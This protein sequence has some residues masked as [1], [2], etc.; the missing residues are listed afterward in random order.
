MP[1][2]RRYGPAMV[3]PAVN[4][5]VN[6]GDGGAKSFL[7]IK[8]IADSAM[9][10]MRPAVT[11]IQTA[12]GEQEALA[13]MEAS[14]P[15]FQV[16]Q[17]SGAQV[18]GGHTPAAQA[19]VA[20]G[21]NPAFQSALD[22]MIADAPGAM[23]VS[24][25][26]RTPET[27]AQ[28][29]ANNMTRAKYGF[30]EAEKAQWLADVASLGAIGAG[31]VWADRFGTARQG[32]ERLRNWIGLPGGSRHQQGLAGDLSFENSDVQAWAHANAANYGL[33][34]PMSWEPW[35]I[36]LQGSRDAAP[37]GQG[38][39]AP[40]I[41]Q[42]PTQV[43]AVIA[44]AAQRHG[45]NPDAMMAVAYLESRFD[46]TEQNPE[47][48]AG[49]LFQF[50]DS[51]AAQYGLVDKM[52]MAQNADA[53][54]RFMKD[55]IAALT[56]ALGR[57]PSI[58]E[59]YL[60]HQQGAQGAIRLLSHPG[61]LAT[62]IV[63]SDAVTLNG[64]REN[65]TA[66]EFAN[67]WID[68]ANQAAGGEAAAADVVGMMAADYELEVTNR[69]SFE[70][71]LPFTIRSAAFNAAADRVIGERAMAAL[72][73]GMAAAVLE[74]DGDL[75]VMRAEMDKVRSTI[76]GQIPTELPGLAVDVQAAYDRALGVAER[77]V[78]ADMH[79]NTID[80]QGAAAAM[81]WQNTEAE[82]NRMAIAGAT[83]D[84]IAAH[85]SQSAARIAQFGP[86]EA[87]TVAGQTFGADPSRAGILTAA[88]IN[89]QVLEITAAATKLMLQA[90]FARS[91][92]PTQFAAEF[93]NAVLSGRSPL[94][95]GESLAL[96]SAMEAQAY[97]A[98]S[99][100]QT[101]ANA[102]RRRLE[103]EMG[104][105]INA[106][107]EMTEAGVPVAIPPE[108]RA[109]IL[110]NLA[111]YPDLQREARIAFRVADAQVQTHG[112]SG[113]ELLAYVD[114][115]RGEI[116]ASVS[117]G[118]VN[119]EAVAVI[120]SLQD[121]VAKIR[122]A[123]TSETLGLPMAE[124]MIRD[125]YGYDPSFYDNLREQAMG[126]EKLIGDITEI[127]MFHRDAMVLDD[128]NAEERA[129]VE[130][131]L[132]AANTALYATGQR[133]GAEAAT[134]GRVLD[135]L[136]EW[137]E[138]RGQVAANDPFIF[139]EMVG[140]SLP[141]LNEAENMA[142]VG[143]V[144]G[145]RVELLAPH[146]M[147]EGVDYPAP[148]RREEADLISEVWRNSSRGEQTAFLAEIA[149]MGEEQAAA[150]FN[151]VGMAEPVM[152]AAG[153]VYNMGNRAAASVILRGA[154]DV[155][156]QEAEA[157]AGGWGGSSAPAALMARNSVIG[158]FI[159]L[160]VFEDEDI[161]A[162]D[163]I[164]DAYARGMAISRGADR[165]TYD[166]I[167]AGY[168]VALGRQEDGSGGVVDTKY[169]AAILPAGWT[170]RRFNRW[171]DDLDDGDMMRMNRGALPREPD[172]SIITWENVVRNIDG[173]RPVPGE[174]GKIIPVNED[175]LPFMTLFRP[176]GAT[177]VQRMPL[178]LDLEDVH[179]Q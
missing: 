162:M 137:S 78:L 39:G 167:A 90:E 33:H 139:A 13:A 165:I 94:P 86:R 156:I 148:L 37:S 49:G 102:E 60:A 12:R 28:I 55:N 97:A 130:E 115:M 141:G 171:I 120:E 111:K 116:Q 117:R 95:P 7:A 99:R 19:T 50:I 3:R 4:P 154:G 105:T 113:P 134:V 11:Q 58:G 23:S 127:E 24:S 83:S 64:G 91:Q 1:S 40:A 68:R 38:Q 179:A 125:G 42:G 101:A 84:E 136:S 106:Y 107:V 34:F 142:Q 14:A 168:Q 48:T 164:A 169:G 17:V 62:A 5:Q 2:I 53:A 152:F 61:E 170:A 109:A 129:I 18:T 77:Q 128:L 76:I 108:E 172:L 153:H 32:A 133:A 143:Q 73:T 138:H 126:D 22:R 177:D 158:D 110:E 163:S 96:M 144:I 27:Q 46:P 51:T 149:K 8:E 29:I 178:V 131:Q 157:E 66:Q 119:F 71:R 59:I 92:N 176:D 45:V 93:K 43:R 80:R 31:A 81:A 112:M 124:Q 175:G 72:Q 20:S 89:D 56:A 26:Y 118:E 104:A 82:A 44:A 79:Q 114:G 65:M 103:E 98:E 69:N 57:E 145:A 174:P 10:F 63:G 166:D 155:K 135:R 70:P 150:I 100:R 140:V 41:A 159:A 74:A 9:E 36:E 30:T 6:L 173:F 132:R 87:F 25:G 54:A 160:D 52:D 47:S 123:V 15:Q 67:L 16:A 151:A 146:T 122:D 121:R 88:E 35:H 161:A 75:T 21:I 85:V 147:R